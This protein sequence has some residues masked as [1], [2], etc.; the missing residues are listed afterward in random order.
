MPIH[1]IIDM[2]AVRNCFVSASGAMGMAALVTGAVV[3]A[4]ASV[5]IGGAD[6]KDVLIDMAFVRVM[7]VSVMQIVDVVFVPDRLMSAIRAVLMR[8]VV[9]DVACSHSCSP[10]SGL[11]QV[12]ARC[13]EMRLGNAGGTSRGKVKCRAEKD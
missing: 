11:A 2:I 3:P 13:G 5:R 9:V 8:M 4:G 12:P 7:Q 1:Q 10:L 6:R